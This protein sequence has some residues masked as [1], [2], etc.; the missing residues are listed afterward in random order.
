MIYGRQCGAHSLRYAGKLLSARASLSHRKLK[1]QNL[2]ELTI[3]FISLIEIM[4]NIEMQWCRYV[5][6]TQRQAT[7]L[8]AAGQ[9]FQKE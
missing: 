6:I 7:P 5:R 9:I 2:Y 4:N 8:S 3:Y 1:A